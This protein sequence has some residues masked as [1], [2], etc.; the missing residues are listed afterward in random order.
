MGSKTL[1]DSSVSVLI[2]NLINKFEN[3][4][5]TFIINLN[6]RNDKKTYEYWKMDVKV[7]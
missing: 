5:N 4:F 6:E 2:D 1:K 3:H 7:L